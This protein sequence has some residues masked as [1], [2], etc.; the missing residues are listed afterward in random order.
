MD[1]THHQEAQ[2][3]TVSTWPLQNTNHRVNAVPGAGGR[4]PMPQAGFR[5]PTP[6]AGY[7]VPMPEAGLRRGPI[8]GIRPGHVAG[9]KRSPEALVTA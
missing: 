1:S 2:M 5:F 4:F 3:I 7:R 8:A 6:D 9:I